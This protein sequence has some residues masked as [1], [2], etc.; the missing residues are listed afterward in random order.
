MTLRIGFIGT[1]QIAG[2]HLNGLAGLNAHVGGDQP[3]YE[4]I[5]LADPRPEARDAL[6]AQAEAKMGR[7]PAVY[8]D[9]R[10][11]LEREQLDAASLLVPHDRHWSIARDCLD[12][13]L[14][15]QVQK[16]IAITIADGR[17]IIDYAAQKQRALVVSEPSVLGRGTRAFFAALRAGALVG[18]PTLL[19]DYAV[20]TLNGGF[21]MN[22]PWRHLKGMAGAGWF[23]DHGVHRTHWFLDAFG[24]VAEAFGAAK[25]IEPERRDEK[26]G[27]FTVDTE[28]AAMTVLRFANGVLGHFLVAS[29]GHGAGFGAVRVYG[30]EGVA[31][32]SGGTAQ[33]DGGEARKLA[34]LTA[35]FANENLPGDAMAHSFGELRDLIIN[36]TP[37]ISSGERALEA[38]AVIYACL[39]SSQTGRSVAVA[40]I[41]SGAA[42]TYE[43]SIEAARAAWTNVPADRV[44]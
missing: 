31:D 4:L 9:Y 11:M 32:L 35:P 12:A 43:D 39:E 42:H 5:A 26:H 27:A 30:S 8:A 2:W 23:L 29:A 19:L 40:D 34:D 37:P 28:D 22:T 16:P 7:R 44:S 33:K 21:F 17:R 10:E 25:T 20:T 6:A 36:N 41:L 14:H 24:S 13:G 18:T 15:L 3:A 1:G 38:L